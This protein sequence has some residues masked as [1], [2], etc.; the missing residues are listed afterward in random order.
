MTSS[1]DFDLFVEVGL[2]RRGMVWWVETE[3]NIVNVN[4]MG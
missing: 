4:K 2:V 3:K 1:K